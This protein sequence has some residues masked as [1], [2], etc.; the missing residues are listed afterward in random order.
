MP[1]GNIYAREALQAL[2]SELE[3]EDEL[4]RG[5]AVD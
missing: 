5:V 4:L 1:L 3:N 2:L